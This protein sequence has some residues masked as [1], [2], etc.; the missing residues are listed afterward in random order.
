MGE[1]AAAFILGFL[2]CL[3]AEAAILAIIAVLGRALPAVL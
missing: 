1:K 3:A 2:S